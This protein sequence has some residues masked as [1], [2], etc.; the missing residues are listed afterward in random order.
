[1]GPSSLLLFSG[2]EGEERAEARE[3]MRW[4]YGW[5]ERWRGEERRGRWR[6]GGE[7][8]GAWYLAAILLM[9][10]EKGRSGR[11]ISATSLVVSMVGT[12]W[13][14]LEEG[15]SSSSSLFLLLGGV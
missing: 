10:E 7:M 4:E 13:S 5:E 6:W 1:M 14:G 2:G 12:L 15:L 11:R 3:A 9:R 8:V